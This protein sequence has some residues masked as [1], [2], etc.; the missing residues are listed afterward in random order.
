M[1]AAITHCFQALK[2]LD[3]FQKKGGGSFS[4]DRDAF[5]WGAQGPDFLFFHNRL[6]KR[7]GK[8]LGEY[9]SRL[10]QGSPLPLLSAL[11][12]YVDRHSGDVSVRS[13]AYGFL[14]HYS[15]D[16]TAHP[17]VYYTVSALRKERPDKSESFLHCSI[18]SVL[19]VIIL[20]YE[21]RI[22][23]T[24]F[25]LKRTVPWNPRVIDAIAKLY[26][27]VLNRLYGAGIREEQVFQAA[28][29]CRRIQGLLNDRTTLKKTIL[30][31]WEKR[32]K[33]RGGYSCFIRGLCEEGGYD[34]ANIL[35]SDWRWPPGSKEIRSESFFDLYDRSIRESAAFMHGFFEAED[36]MDLT[37]E[38]P[39]S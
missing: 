3:E 33:S 20:R 27:D 24:D 38:I 31:A 19:D 21:R 14:C 16:R 29:D 6:P 2:A 1:P 7:K 35:A 11:R 26:A 37:G 12:G 36:L 30:Q 15:L 28:K 17:Y 25:D 13:Y 23:P 22:L 39:F 4:I 5:L 18:E 10:H 9:G 8:S 32:R 34:Y